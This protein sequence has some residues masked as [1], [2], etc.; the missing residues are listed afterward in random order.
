MDLPDFAAIRVL[1]IGDVMIDRF[2]SGRVERISPEGPVPIIRI[3]ATQ[4]VPGGAANVGRNVSALGGRCTLVGAVGADAAGAEL[5][6]MLSICGRIDPA[7]VA[8]DGR[9][10][11]EKIRFVASGQTLLRADREEP[12]EV[13]EKGAHALVAAI[14]DRIADHH[15]LVLSDYAKG[16]L[17]DTV[18]RRVIDAAID[19]GIPVVVDPKSVRL[20]RYAGA[21]V[22]TPNAREAGIATGID[23]DTDE[24]AARAAIQVMRDAAIGSI[25]LTRSERG[26]T[27]V[28]ADGAVVHVPTTAREVFDVVGAG[29]TVVATLALCL[30]AGMALEPA[31]RIA[32]AAAGI[33]VGKHGTA[34]ASRSE[35]AE[36]LARLSRSAGSPSEAKVMSPLHAAM[37][38][39]QWERDG[40]TVG[41][42]NGC[43]D[44]LHVGHVGILEFARAQCDRLIV[45]VND[46]ASVTRLKG[47]SRPLTPEE[48]RAR[49]LGAFSFVDAVVLF[50]HD[51]PRALIEELQPD[52]LVKGADY[53]IEDI[54]GH[55]IVQKRGGR[56]VRFDL[57]PGRSTTGTIARAA[58]LVEVSA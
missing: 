5:G 36:E 3:D 2:V 14:R 18:I 53:A 41:F 49:M 57:V 8:D 25:L 56:V 37:L 17:T 28:T 16:V 52:V 38:R 51:T 10:T 23:I 35:L 45:G 15:V 50:E 21:T 27:L 43:F 12:R 40:L 39:R 48:D 26:M 6:A 55:D 32:N 20:A 19:A 44:I 9:L 29:D 22:V 33:V 4:S 30:G 34:T 46:D 47:P 11:I 54:V 24:S 42:T 13:S 7:L 31:A 1:C 58:G